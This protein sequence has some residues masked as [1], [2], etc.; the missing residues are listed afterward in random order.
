[1]DSSREVPA[2]PR[3]RILW[4]GVNGIK[5]MPESDCVQYAPERMC[6]VAI[7]TVL[8]LRR[9]KLEGKPDI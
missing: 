2:Y 1:M 7:K 6:H 9:V 4:Y 8:R 5:K 3:S